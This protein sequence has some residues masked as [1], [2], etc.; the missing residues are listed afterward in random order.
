VG[1]QVVEE[2]GTVHVVE[3]RP[4]GPD[5]DLGLRHAPQQ[6]PVDHSGHRPH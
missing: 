6:G 2:L 1:G 5:G 4:A 3:G